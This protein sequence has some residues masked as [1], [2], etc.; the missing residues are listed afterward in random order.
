MVIMLTE[1][2]QRCGIFVEKKANQ[3]IAVRDK[4]SIKAKFILRTELNSPSKLILQ[5]QKK[6]LFRKEN[7][8]I[9]KQ[10]NISQS[11]Y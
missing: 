4:N 6:V 8:L 7:S 10:K 2:H 1:K 9:F 5:K 11:K 3:L